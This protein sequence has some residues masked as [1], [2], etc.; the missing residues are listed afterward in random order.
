MALLLSALAAGCGGGGGGR[1]PILGV[2]NIV[3]LPPTV[4]AVAPV[5]NA[6]GVPINNT[7]ITAAFS[8]PM[9]P[10]TGS[11]TFTITCAAPCANATGTVALDATNRIATFTTAA[12]LAPLTLYT[13]TIT[14]ARSIATGLALAAPY[15]WQF[16]T[17]LA[18]DTT[19]PRVTLTDPA[20]TIPGPT[21]NV[22]TNTAITAVFTEDMAPL[23]IAAANFNV[24]GPGTTPVAGTVSYVV[25][26]RTAVFKPTAIL[27]AGTTYTATITTGATDL[28]GNALAGNQAALPAASNYIWTFDTS[29][30]PIAATN[31]SVLSTYPFS[32]SA[33]LCPGSTINATF[34]LPTGLRMD[35]LTVNSATFT[36]TGPA[37]ALTPVVAASVVIDAATGQTATFTTMNNLTPNVTYTATI[38]GGANGVKDLAIP[39]D[40]MANDFSW[41]FTAGSCTAAIP[42]VT[43]LGTASTFGIMATAAITN[44]GNSIINGN[45]SLDPGT[46]ISGFGAGPNYA[47]P[48]GVVN[49]SVHIND[50]VSAQARADLLSA[51]NYY[52]GLPPGVTI[53]GGADL[54]ALYPGGIPPGT[55]TSGSTMLVS[56]PLVLNSGG[57]AGAVWVFQIGSSLTAGANV[58][59]NGGSEKNVFWVTTQD[60]TIGAPGNTF[61]GNLIT[62]RDANS[63]GGIINGAILAGAI[64]AG[65]VA[66]SSATTINVPAP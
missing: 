27:A 58:T 3:A 19:R 38:K 23:T 15:I 18:P 56:T 49:G 11:A 33:G 41:N 9:S 16:T 32:G 39:A 43:H 60:A 20:T 8:E 46:S 37:P 17:G 63:N 13:G 4:T 61:S 59:M 29:A 2:G 14:G 7:I 28:A 1:D 62:G 57:N 12:N 44:T 48:P 6:A 64:T 54:G 42:P 45:V 55:Y 52:K 35:P 10:L 65:T 34:S 47:G 66:L 40:I 24:T 26:S 51:Y 25:G 53:A 5:N 31:I 30:P 50:S 21:S 22:P 36:V